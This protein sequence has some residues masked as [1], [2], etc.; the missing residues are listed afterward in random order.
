MLVSSDWLRVSE[1]LVPLQLLKNRH[2]CLIEQDRVYRFIEQLVDHFLHRVMVD[3]TDSVAER[4]TEQPG[5]SGRIRLVI[6]RGKAEFIVLRVFN[7]FSGVIRP[8]IDSISSRNSLP[9]RDSPDGLLHFID[10][11]IGINA[12]QHRQ[13]NQKDR[14]Q[15]AGAP[16]FR[17]FFLT[18][19]IE[20]QQAFKDPQQ[21]KY[22]NT[23]D[24]QALRHHIQPLDIQAGPD[25]RCDL[26][27]PEQH[28]HN[29]S[30]YF[31]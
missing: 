16:L 22:D 17:A 18:V 23:I 21:K 24:K 15:T 27:D 12:G 29:R 14:R 19:S 26:T 3:H 10:R 20:K 7:R 6:R 2:V 13:R 31:Q 30:D 8:D 4:L 28:K 11:K 5:R 25:F 1:V 9:L